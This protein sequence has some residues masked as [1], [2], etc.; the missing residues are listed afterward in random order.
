M[1]L[2]QKPIRFSGL[3]V[4]RRFLGLTRGAIHTV[5]FDQD[6]Q[7]GIKA[8][9]LVLD[10]I[11]FL[12]PSNVAGQWIDAISTHKL[13][14]SLFASSNGLIQRKD[15]TP[16]TDSDESSNKHLIEATK[17]CLGFQD[18]EALAKGIG[19]ARNSISAIRHGRTSLGIEPRLA[20]LNRIE[21][22]PLVQVIDV[23]NSAEKLINEIRSWSAQNK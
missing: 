2:H 7:L 20:I 11:A 6:R 23:L 13:I 4:S 16:S 1:P 19:L 17:L 21:A 5:R 3:G 8:R 12:R 9:F 10:R 18:D 22:F 14:E 15:N